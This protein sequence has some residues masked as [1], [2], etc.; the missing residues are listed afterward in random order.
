MESV[1][2]NVQSTARETR[3]SVT[4]VVHESQPK[5]TRAIDSVTENIQ[6]SAREAGNS[7]KEAA[8]EAQPK[9]RRAMENVSDKI[10]S[11]VSETAD[12]VKEVAHEAQPKVTRAIDNV[13]NSME[14]SVSKVADSVPGAAQDQNITRTPSMD[15]TKQITS[16][17]NLGIDDPKSFDLAQ[18]EF[19]RG[20]KVAGQGDL[21]GA[22]AAFERAIAIMPES[23]E[24]HYNLGVVLLQQAKESEGVNHIRQAR[25]LSRIEGNTSAAQ[26]LER[27]LQQIK[28]VS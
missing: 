21:V 26:A 7:V 24:L 11:S 13:T 27:I 19:E 10:E 9:M 5:I 1:A 3:E 17:T 23:P 16:S 14:S 6:S 18:S 28:V 20:I 22:Q 25:D 15:L 12:S 2:E 8:H 4:E